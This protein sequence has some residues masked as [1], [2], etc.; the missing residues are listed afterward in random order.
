M[1]TITN[2]AIATVRSPMN[3]KNL[4]NQFCQQFKSQMISKE[5]CSCRLFWIM[6]KRRKLVSA[7]LNLWWKKEARV[8]LIPMS[9]KNGKR[10]KLVS[11]FTI[12]SRLWEPRS[13]IRYRNS[14]KSSNEQNHEMKESFTSIGGDTHTYTQD[15]HTYIHWIFFLSHI[16]KVNFSNP[17]HKSYQQFAFLKRNALWNE[18]RTQTERHKHVLSWVSLLRSSEIKESDSLKRRTLTHL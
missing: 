18:Y 14:A 12:R 2:P 1:S 5:E 16:W 11:A 13:K 6:S 8:W 7:N 10:R 3:V 9:T 17:Y 4:K 15:T